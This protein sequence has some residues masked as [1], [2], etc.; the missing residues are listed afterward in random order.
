MP[1]THVV[2]EGDCIASIAFGNG[3]H[4]DTVWRDPANA[5]LRA[6]RGNPNVLLAGDEVVVPDLRE[7]RV[8]AATGRRHRFRRRGVPE[9]LRM[10]VMDSDQPRAGVA[11]VL[12]IDGARREG[13]ADA[14]GRIEE[15]IPPGARAGKLVIGSGE[16]ADEIDLQLGGLDPVT[17][18]AGVR[19]RLENLGFL[20]AASGEEASLDAAVRLFRQHHGLPP[21][22]AL[23]AAARSALLEAHGS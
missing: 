22:D 15:W 11:Y 9:K 17:T 4:P 8:P 7:K 13:R 2:A 6:L 16:D 1:I 12:E 21:G 19:A 5:G 18:E 20:H 14:E 10:Q 23:D 3:F